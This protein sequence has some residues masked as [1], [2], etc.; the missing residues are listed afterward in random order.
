MAKV[1]TETTE[2]KV[3]TARNPESIL[4]GLLSLPLEDKITLCKSLK[5]SIQKEVADK[6]ESAKAAKEM[7]NGL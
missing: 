6:E 7:V 2:K 3:R 1:S 4:K 5:D